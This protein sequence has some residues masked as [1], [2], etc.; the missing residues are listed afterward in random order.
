M[1]QLQ[2]PP[3]VEAV[4]HSFFTCEFTTLG[5][6][7]TPITW[8]L[9]PVYWPSRG[10]FVVFTSIGLPQKA[11]NARR[12][13]H[14]SLLWSDSTGSDLVSPPTVLVQGDAVCPDSVPSSLKALDP[15]LFAA[16]KA[17]TRK[18]LKRQPGM[19]LYLSNALSR[20]LMEW[21]FIRL[22]ITITPRRI[23]WWEQG[24]RSRAPQTLEVTHVA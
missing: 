21:Y 5:K 7:R 4:F 23:W 11:L 9:L 24:D 2:V 10:Q 3:H 20:Y 13:P 14:S 12:N 17:Q 1:S 6:D 19:R 15:D 8:P 16:L 18:L 22:M